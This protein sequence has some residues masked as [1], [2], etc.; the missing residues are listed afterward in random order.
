MTSTSSRNDTGSFA[1][2][3]LG[4]PRFPVGAGLAG[5]GFGENLMAML[6]DYFSYYRKSSDGLMRS[7]SRDL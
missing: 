6:A 2:A 3:D 4:L 7:Y 5:S 1:A